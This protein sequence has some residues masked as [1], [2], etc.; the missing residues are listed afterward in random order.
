MHFMH[1]FLYIFGISPVNYACKP[2]RQCRTY[3]LKVAQAQ[4]IY[5]FFVDITVQPEILR[6][7][8]RQCRQEVEGGIC[9]RFRLGV[10]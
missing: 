2:A 10:F 8:L 6:L 3:I 9:G 1:S 4:T 7:L 5:K